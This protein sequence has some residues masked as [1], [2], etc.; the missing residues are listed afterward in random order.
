VG[1]EELDAL[2]ILAFCHWPQRAAAAGLNTAWRVAL[3][4]QP[5]PT[6]TAAAR[7]LVADEARVTPCPAYISE[8]YWR[9]LCGRLSEEFA[10]YVPMCALVDGGSRTPRPTI[11]PP[12]GI[13]GSWQHLFKELYSLARRAEAAGAPETEAESFQIEVAVRFRPAQGPLVTPEDDR[14][15]LPLHQKVQLVKQQLGC[16]SKEAVSLIMRK[17]HGIN[18]YARGLVSGDAAGGLFQPCLCPNP[19]KENVPLQLDAVKVESIEASVSS[20]GEAALGKDEQEPDSAANEADA[21]CS[22]LSIHEETASVLTITRQSGLREFS[23]DRAFGEAVP[24]EDIYELTVRRL[25]MEFL[26]GTSASIIC[27]GQTASG[28]THTMFG[29]SGMMQLGHKVGQEVRGIVPRACAEVLSM[30]QGWRARGLEV[31][32]GVSYVEL[33]GNEVS[34][35]LREGRVVGQGVEG[36]YSAVRATDRVGHRYVLDGHTQLSVESLAEIDELLRVGDEAKRRAATAM[37]ERSTRAHTIFVLSLAVQSPGLAPGTGGGAAGA[38]PTRRLSRFFFADLGGSE[39]LSK[40]KADEGTQ[41]PVM[42]VGGEELSRLSWQEYYSTRQRVQETLNINKGLFSLKRVIEALHQRSRMSSEGVPQQLLPYVPY[43]DSKLTMLLREALGGAARTVVVAT[44]TLDPRH[45]TESLQTLRFA[46]TCAQVQNRREADEAASA[47][48]GQIAEEIAGLQAEITKKERWETRL[49]RRCD[50]DTVAGA[51]G[52]SEEKVNRVE[53][54]PTSVLVGAEEERERLEQLLER[55]AELQ[56]LSDLGALGKDYRAMAATAAVDGG[57]GVDFRERDR[58][59]A[60]TKARDFEDEGVLADAVR[61]LFR[62]AAGAAAAFGETEWSTK[63]R[64]R[65][66]Q[67]PAGYT[68]V[69]RALRMAWEDKTASGAESRPFGKAM[70]DR[71]QAWAAAFKADPSGRDEALRAL[72]EECAFEIVPN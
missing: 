18:S 20:A 28:K 21:R 51:F 3:G 46:E 43:Q 50:V 34:D 19:D 25:V 32:L 56:G 44:A 45:A 1:V 53:V 39:Q 57:R 16:T 54:V 36:R 71:C 14:V 31:Q 12:P 7:T 33:F 5:R 70:L 37:N 35:L 17:R 58:F 64:L 6:T 27:Y 66:D 60:R 61:F 2:G 9:F 38:T 41:A 23:F 67:I 42:V 49:I 30:M 69:A 65:R 59:S 52:E 48:L 8:G 63:R 68:R 10:I 40:S 47:A 26:N 22:I 72:L 15:V 55:Q 11:A 24:Q 13:S 62:K 4:L 29:P